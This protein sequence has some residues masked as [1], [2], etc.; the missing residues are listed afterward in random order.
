MRV[1]VVGAG[2]VGLTT[3]V[4]LSSK[5]Q[6]TTVDVDQR[7]INSINSG[8]APFYE[9]GMQEL[10][11]AAVENGR[12]K[13]IQPQ[14]QYSPHDFVIFCVGTP[15]RE[16]G[17]VNID[18]LSDAVK[19]IDNAFDT[20]VDEY[21][22]LAVRSTVPPGTTRSHVCNVL[23]SNHNNVSFGVVFNPEF[24][25]QGTAIDDISTPDRVVIGTSDRKAAQ[26]YRELYSSILTNP[27]TKILETSIESAELAKY[28][29]NCFLATKVSFANEISCIA[30]RLSDVDIDDVMDAVTS[31]SRINPSH[32]KAG[33]GFGGTCLPKDLS[34]LIRYGGTFGL[35]MELLSS[36]NEVNNNTA[37]RLMQLLNGKV[38]DLS[39]RKV[40]V[41]G[42]TFKSGTDDTRDS[43]SLNLIRKLHAAGADV[44]AHDPMANENMFPEAFKEMIHRC[45]TVEECTTGAIAIFLMTDWPLYRDMGVQEIVSNMEIKLFIDG[46]RLFARSTI[47]PGVEYI[48]FG[49]KK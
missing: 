37:I 20:L 24:M 25:K 29:S 28:A 12:L 18:Y 34:G 31:D 19:N 6:V 40:C 27:E 44:W 21:L 10:L 42:L 9:K 11:Q 14:S 47:P 4:V 15:P 23:S 41:L 49:T 48:C 1:L 7:K 26:M 32:M 17:S 33:L 8:S 30:E 16:D 46:R 39:S 36:V 5:H 35:G 45:D 2:Y 13:A 22:V 43:Q 3:A 38:S